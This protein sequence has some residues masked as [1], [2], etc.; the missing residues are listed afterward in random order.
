[1]SRDDDDMDP[2]LAPPE[3]LFDDDDLIDL[4]ATHVRVDGAEAKIK[5][6]HKLAE[7]IDEAVRYLAADLEVFWQGSQLVH[8]TRAEA[9]EDDDS[10]TRE[11][12]PLVRQLAIASLRERLTRV[13]GFLKFVKRE[14]QWVNT[15]P[16]E[17]LIQGLAARGV[18]SGIRELKGI[19]EAPGMRPDGSIIDSPGYD[20]ATGF[21]YAPT[22]D[23]PPVAAAPTQAAAV[24]A[25]AELCEVFVDF[26]FVNDAARMVPVAL[27][28][29]LIVRPAVRGSVPAFLFDAPTAGT[30]KTL[31]ADA[32]CIIATGR[33]APRGTFPVTNRGKVNV[34]ELEKMLASDAACSKAIVGFDNVSGVFGGAPLD[35]VI[36]AGGDTIDFRTLGKTESRRLPWPGIVVASG[37]N[38]A[39]LN[40]TVR[41]VLVCRIESDQER[42]EERKGFA[43]DPLLPW[44]EAQRPRLVGAALT[45]LRA[46]VVAGRPDGGVEPLGSF[47]AWSNL[48]ARAIVFAGGADVLKARARDDMTA[49][50]GRAELAAI[51]EGWESLQG[52]ARGLTV[53][54]ALG[55]LYPSSRRHGENPPDEYDFMRA[56]LEEVCE[57]KPGVAPSVAQVAYWL[58]SVRGRLVNGRKLVTLSEHSPAKWGVRGQKP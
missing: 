2:K 12:T 24:H 1:M 10:S 36:T 4:N 5:L 35:K 6:G 15:L 39:V 51:L 57:S 21:L 16:S 20:A 27:T 54:H 50:D 28:L 33:G 8:V 17:P 23:F 25:L 22:I 55:A 43:H 32:C 34:E 19:I 18:W 37:N 46:F 41:R 56:A 47:D 14:G 45:L 49:S 53:K 29:S 26:P 11:G 30:G 38:V 48:I 31:C 52:D 42:P 13:C 7:N 3:G 58:R 44:V 9:T 40:D